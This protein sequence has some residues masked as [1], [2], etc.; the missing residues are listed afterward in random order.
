MK[1]DLSVKLGPLTLKNPIISAAGPV[2]G[3]KQHLINAC[4]AGFGAI[5]TKT[6]SYYGEFQRYP[7]PV[8]NICDV[9]VAADDPNGISECSWMHNDHNSVY[10]PHQFVKFLPEVAEH[11]RKNNCVLIGSFAGAGLEQWEMMAV[12]YVKAGCQALE[13]NFC[14]PYPQVMPE[15]SKGNEHLIGQTFGD[16]PALGVEVIK[17]LKQVVDVP[18]FPKMPPTTRKNI[19]E[20]SK[21][22]KE[23][24]ADGITMYANS[25]VLKIDIET[26]EPMGWGASI[27]SSHG[28]MMDTCEDTA[29]VAKDVPGFPIMSGRGARYWYDCI[30]LLMAGAASVQYSAAIHVYGLKHVKN[31]LDDMEKWLERKGYE[32]IEQVK[33]IALPKI[34]KS[35]DVKNKVKPVVAKVDGKKCIACGR[36]VDV[37]FYDGPELHVKNGKGAAV[38]NQDHCAGCTI[39]AQV[40]PKKCISFTERNSEEEYLRALGSAHPELL[41]DIF[42]TK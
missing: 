40:C 38:I 20:I 24:G 19:V 8:Y 35:A 6:T 37:C 28:H 31:M 41:P 36:C 32:S 13:L 1:P 27:G 5:I 17:R 16:N 30:E 29:K 25:M 9:R 33:G 18:I 15:T 2:G 7:R 10:P 39:C 26:G 42:G 34:Y 14:C 11:C 3:T 12:E 21:M 22:Y 4:D 23:A